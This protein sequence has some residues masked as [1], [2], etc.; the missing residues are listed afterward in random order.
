MKVKNPE[1]IEAFRQRILKC[2]KTIISQEGLEQ[3]SIRKIANML[4][5]TP[6]IIY[7]YFK[8]KDAI[9]YEIT[10]EGCMGILQIIKHHMDPSAPPQ[11][12]LINTLRAYMQGML[13]Q[14]DIFLLLMLSTDPNVEAQVNILKENIRE[15]RA[16]MQA[17]CNILEAGVAQGVFQCEHIELRAQ[18]IWCATFGMIQR[19]VKEKI[20]GEYQ[21]LLIEEHL[22]MIK[23][24]LEVRC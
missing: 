2:A 23:D 4:E 12:V 6:G 14:A 11:D 9:L 20:D 5:Y 15:E 17:L 22:R 13:K 19:I 8:D 21:M 24:S 1:Q 3:L 7:H 16:S 18:A 10:K